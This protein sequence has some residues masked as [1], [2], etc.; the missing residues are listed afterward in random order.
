MRRHLH[1]PG[2][3]GLYLRE[4]Q[5]NGVKELTCVLCLPPPSSINFLL[6]APPCPTAAS[7]SNA[8][9]SEGGW[10]RKES[11]C[12]AWCLLLSDTRCE[13]EMKGDEA[14]WLPMPILSLTPR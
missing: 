8:H 9:C 11:K 13:G 10:G 4:R 14:G 2:I 1:V 12:I 6:L 3:V 5:D 7:P